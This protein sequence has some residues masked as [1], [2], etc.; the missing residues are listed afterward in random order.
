MHQMSS[1]NSRIAFF[2]E[3]NYWVGE[4]INKEPNKCDN[5]AW[6]NTDDLPNNLV[7][8]VKQAIKY[9]REGIA[10]SDFGWNL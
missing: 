4:V 2:F 3:I 7:P 10:Y 9:W 5:L 6:Y 8:Y 1:G